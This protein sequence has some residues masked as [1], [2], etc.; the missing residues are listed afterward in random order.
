MKL[1]PIVLDDKLYLGHAAA[2]RELVR[3]QPLGDL[4]GVDRCPFADVIGYDPE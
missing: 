4:H 1:A 3:K 2:L